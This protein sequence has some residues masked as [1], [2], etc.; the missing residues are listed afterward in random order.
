MDD[1]PISV[2]E[3]ATHDEHINEGVPHI[4]EKPNTA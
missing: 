1:N 3:G 4:V 2:K